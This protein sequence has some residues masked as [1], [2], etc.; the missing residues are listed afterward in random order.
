MHDCSV[1]S[2][3]GAQLFGAETEL[4]GAIQY[5]STAP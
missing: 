5:H 4:V 2:M 1:G 3:I